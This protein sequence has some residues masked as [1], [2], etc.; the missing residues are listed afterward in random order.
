VAAGF[1]VH[2]IIE[3]SPFDRDHALI[4]ATF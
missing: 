1:K 2:K 3:L 4:H